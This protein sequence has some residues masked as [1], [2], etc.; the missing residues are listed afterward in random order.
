[1]MDP[2]IENSVKRIVGEEIRKSQNDLLS[3]MEGMFSIK[4]QEFDHQQKE[5]SELQ[6][7]RLQNELSVN[8][9]YKFQRKSCEDQFKFNRKLSVTLKEADASLEYRDPSAGLAKQKIAEGNNLHESDVCDLVAFTD[10]SEIGVGDYIVPVVDS[11]CAES[12]CDS[13]EI[14]TDCGLELPG[15]SLKTVVVT[16]LRLN[17][18]IKL[19]AKSNLK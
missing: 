6:M 8:D 16:I 12:V 5:R 10:A 14:L 11:I 3:Q 7:N 18:K 19:L 1:M 13:L 2:D 4:L 15:N 9:D 17:V